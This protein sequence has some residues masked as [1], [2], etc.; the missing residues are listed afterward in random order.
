MTPTTEAGRGLHAMTTSDLLR[1]LIPIIEAEAAA[2][3]RERLAGIVEG[4]RL[5]PT[6]RADVLVAMRGEP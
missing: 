4:L 3:E 5:Q 1:D 6:I 2:A